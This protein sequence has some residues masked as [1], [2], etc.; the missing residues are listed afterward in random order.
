MSRSL[1][2]LQAVYAQLLEQLQDCGQH[3]AAVQDS[4]QQPRSLRHLQSSLAHLKHLIQTQIMILE[5]DQLDP[6]IEAKIAHYLQSLNIEIDKQLR[7]LSVDALFL[8]SAKQPATIA[9][10]LQQ[11]GDR[12]DR[13][14]QY[15]TAALEALSPGYETPAS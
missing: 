6:P 15:A 4:S 2:P 10:R 14:T 12:C 5:F 8:Q 11:M 3:L 7:L 13:L 1:E 9:Q